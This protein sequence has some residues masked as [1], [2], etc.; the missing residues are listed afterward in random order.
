LLSEPAPALLACLPPESIHA[1]LI[2]GFRVNGC[3][4]GNGIS[5][6]RLPAWRGRPGILSCMTESLVR[7]PRARVTVNTCIRAK[8]HAFMHEGLD[9]CSFPWSSWRTPCLTV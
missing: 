9:V 3:G 2:A 7:S 1:C 4:I 5:R 8:H 6:F